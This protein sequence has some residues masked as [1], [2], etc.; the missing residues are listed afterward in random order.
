MEIH[1]DAKT[2]EQARL[3]CAACSML[4]SPS[5]YMRLPLTTI[6]VGLV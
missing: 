4:D 6:G 1:Y 3:V 5:G 2:K